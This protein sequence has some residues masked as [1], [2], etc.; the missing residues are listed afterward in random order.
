MKRKLLQRGL[1]YS[2]S[3]GF[4]LM[5]IMVALAIMGIALVVVFQ[6]FSANMRGIVASGDYIRASMLAEQKMGQIL[7]NDKLVEGS[8][9][10]VTED[11]RRIDAVITDADRKR[12]DNLPVKLLKIVVT[13]HWPS[14]LGERK[15][16]LQTF[17][18]MKKQV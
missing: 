6:L 7:D 14:G 11:G 2:R 16:T 1:S 15:I 5:E 13:V 3:E 4:T 18:L 17:K 8:T 12:T 10:D 9:S